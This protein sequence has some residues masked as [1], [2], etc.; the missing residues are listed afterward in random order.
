MRTSL[1]SLPWRQHVPVYYLHLQLAA[2]WVLACL[3]VSCA[4]EDRHAVATRQASQVWWM[5]Q[6]RSANEVSFSACLV[7]WTLPATQSL[8]SLEA[9][10]HS[11]LFLSCLLHSS[12]Y[13]PHIILPF[14]SGSSRLFQPLFIFSN[15]VSHSSFHCI[16]GEK[17]YYSSA[18]L[19]HFLRG[20]LFLGVGMQLLR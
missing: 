15:G 20:Y 7:G 5:V 16:M 13:F 10:G 11:L 14:S 18:A 3:R 12:L 6:P 19:H 9:W 17:S 2:Q 1:G 4:T 8:L